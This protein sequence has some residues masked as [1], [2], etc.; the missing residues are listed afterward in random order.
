ME[1]YQMRHA[2]PPNQPRRKTQTAGHAT[3]ALPARFAERAEEALA[4]VVFVQLPAEALDRFGF[5]DIAAGLPIPV[6]MPGKVAKFDPS[7]I[8]VESVVAGILRVLAWRPGDRN[9]ESYRELAKA[10]RP[11][12]MA[13]LSDAAVSKAQS[14]EWDIAEEIFLALKG[15]YPERPEPTLDLALLYEERAKTLVNE[16]RA[17][18]AEELD[19]AAHA[20]YAELLKKEPPFIDAYYHAAFFF[21]RSKSFERAVSLL[22]SYISLASDDEK[23]GTAKKVLDKLK[24][25]GYLDTTFKEAYDF[26]R[27]GELERGLEK[28]LEFASRYP[29]VWNGW[30]LVGWAHRKMGSWREGVEAFRKAIACGSAEVDTY[31]ELAICLMETGDLSGAKLQLEKALRSEPEN[32]K[33]IVNLGALAFRRGDAE[34]AASFF[35]TALEIDPEDTQARDW[36]ARIET[37]P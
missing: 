7:Y 6:Q 34:E 18:E 11:G 29:G 33:I 16:D 32:L 5:I 23:I 15:L 8:S 28:A 36:L 14:R 37:T 26:I 4:S 10:V 30:F 3:S 20:L 24:D 9:A 21:I 35:R 31:N 19:E 17:S 27:M 25:L 1:G 13:E 2:S 22:T 12:L